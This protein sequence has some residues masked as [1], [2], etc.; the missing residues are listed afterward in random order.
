VVLITLIGEQLATEGLEFTYIGSSNECKNCKLKNVCFHLNPGHNYT[1]TKIREKK[2]PCNI[3]EGK[4]VI[5]EVNELPFFAAVNKEHS[6]NTP[7]TIDRKA[8]DNIKCDYF[9]LC[10]STARHNDKS[11][12]IKKSEGKI[13]C[14]YD[15][16]LYKVELID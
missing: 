10:S 3:H 12:A 13:N 5:I 11:Y 4:A 1:I 7:I 9:E 16:E 8:C 14:P 2:H 6:G 15:I